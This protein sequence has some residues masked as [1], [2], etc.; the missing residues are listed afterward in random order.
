MKI[1]TKLI[2]SFCIIIL[3]PVILF[4]LISGAI[5]AQ[6]IRELTN[7]AKENLQARQMFNTLVL[8]I[9]CILVF[10]AVL[11]LLW[12]YRSIITPIRKLRNA[13]DNIKEGNLD[14]CVDVSGAD[15]IGELGEAFE[16]MRRQLK[17]NAE[18]KLRDEQ[19]SRALISNIA[20]DL[21]TPI[22][23]VK[24]YAEGILDGVANTP[25]KVDKYVRTI[26][27]KATEMNTL[28]N[29]LT[30]YS[31]IDTNRIPYNFT[32]IHVADY[33]NDCIE[34][35]GMD[36][37]SRSIALSYYNYVTEDV[38]IIADPEQLRRVISNIISNSVKYMD[39]ANGVINF[40]IKDV[41]D[42][43]QV[44]IE[45]NGRGIAAHDLPYVFDRFFRADASRNSATGGS[46]IGLSI[47]KKIIE[48]HGGKIW[49]T[50][51]EGQG[52]TMV[53]VIRKYQET[54][55][56]ETAVN[57]EDD[58]YRDAEYTTVEDRRTK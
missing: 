28:I 8:Y 55:M 26:Y 20:H 24:G 18:E 30:L 6:Q 29:E 37:E 5:Y 47:V 19:E 7:L 25:E 17:D 48:D 57:D 33:F 58:E 13:A 4:S 42:F 2:I 41:G 36:L 10:T 14:F 1:K 21:K 38:Q 53:F 39:K 56:N 54:I 49:A 22:T 52:T 12:V 23:A 44:E 40:R 3:V 51:I 34:E 35:I 45:D 15:E 31:K 50:S 43:I 32:K 46:G 27:N 16:S 11:L 9:V